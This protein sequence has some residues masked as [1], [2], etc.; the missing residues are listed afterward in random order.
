MWR[1]RRRSHPSTG[2]DRKEPSTRGA[3]P[4]GM[5]PSASLDVRTRASR[6]RRRVLVASTAP[7]ATSTPAIAVR[8]TRPVFFASL[9]ARLARPTTAIVLVTAPTAPRSRAAVPADDG[10]VSRRWTWSAVP[11]SRTVSLLRVSRTAAFASAVD[12]GVP[13]LVCAILRSR[14]GLQPCQRLAQA[15]TRLLHPKFRVA[16]EADE[17][18]GG[19]RSPAGQHYADER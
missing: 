14:L 18:A 11:A 17:I 2:R 6:R 7:I 13:G 8:R 1:S 15:L 10:T 4:F 12:A 3:I 16:H 19:E 5:V 9:H